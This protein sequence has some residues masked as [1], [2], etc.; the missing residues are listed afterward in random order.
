MKTGL[1]LLDEVRIASPCPARWEDMVG[2]NRSRHCRSC[3][4]TVYDLSELTATQALALI[5]EK[6]GDLCVRLFRRAD[7]RVLTADCPVGL[8]AR[9]G[10]AGR[11]IGAAAWAGVASILC[12]LGFVFLL[13]DGRSPQLPHGNDETVPNEERCLGKLALPDKDAPEPNEIRP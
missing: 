12:L 7:G 4:K 2:D 8:A 1:T 13:R 6:Q 3:N 5:H 11:R 9:L 10:K